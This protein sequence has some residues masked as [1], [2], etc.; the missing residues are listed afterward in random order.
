MWLWNTEGVLWRKV[1]N[2]TVCNFEKVSYFRI[3]RFHVK[4][5]ICAFSGRSGTRAG[6][7]YPLRPLGWVWAII[8]PSLLS[9]LLSSGTLPD[10][11]RTDHLWILL[12]FQ[13]F[14]DWGGKDCPVLFL[15]LINKLGTE[16]IIVLKIMYFGSK[17]GPSERL[18]TLGFSFEI[19]IDW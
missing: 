10:P 1:S 11:V 12:W 3:T 19:V 6:R 13:S 5:Q 16:L 2:V 8:L 7:K 9:L 4:I 18:N 17:Q 15:W 14:V